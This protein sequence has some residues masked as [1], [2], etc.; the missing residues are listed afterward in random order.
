MNGATDA[1]YKMWW[2]D[3][4]NGILVGEIASRETIWNTDD[5]GATLNV[6]WNDSLGVSLQFNS[7]SFAPENPLIGVACR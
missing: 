3:A 4:S 2:F 7:V 1:I 6:V 5:G